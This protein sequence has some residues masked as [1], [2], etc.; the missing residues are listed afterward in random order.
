VDFAII[1]MDY[2]NIKCF[3]IYMMK[4]KLFKILFPVLVFG[5]FAACSKLADDLP[6]APEITTHNPGISDTG[7]TGFHS[8]LVLEAPNGMFDCQQCHAADWSGGIT[9]VGCNTTD[10][11][12]SIN[13]HVEGIIDNTSDDFHG[14]FIRQNGWKL[15]DCQK[16]HGEDYGGGVTSP[17]CL[18]CHSQPEGPEACNTCH[19]DFS[20][21][22]IIAPP[23]DTNNNT[24]TDAVGVGAH[25]T[26]LYQNDI[27]KQIPCSTC[28]VVP[29]DYSDPGHAVD[30]PLPAE[31][32]F[33]PLAVHNIAVNPVYDYSSATCSDTYCH[34]NWAF[35]RD[36]SDYSFAYE[37]SVMIGNN[38]SVVWNE[39]GVGQ[40]DCGSC[41][42]LPPTGHMPAAIEFCSTCHPDIVDPDGNIID[43]TKHINGEKNV[44]GN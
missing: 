24:S 2:K 4:K 26:H 37:D 18:N 33:S 22:A 7:S 27:G 17:T 40:A 30:D 31:V 3:K 39:V 44:F 16:C 28:H 6:P 42:G 20:D 1:V 9:G 43:Q 34:G 19:G 15:M 25:Y 14:D 41:H 11:H 36:S 29:Q 38:I 21:P 32:I 23:Q 10:C 12:P 8:G 35:L 5:V 13:V